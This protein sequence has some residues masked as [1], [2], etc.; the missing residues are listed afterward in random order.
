MIVFKRHWFVLQKQSKAFRVC[1]DQVKEN[2]CVVHVDFSEN[3]NC[4]YSEEIQAVHFGASHEQASLHTVVIYSAKNEPV[5]LCTVSSNLEH[6]PVGIWAHL[7]PVLW[8]IQHELPY[9]EHITMWSDGPS[10]Q[11]KQKNIFFRLC[12]DPFTYGF[13]SVSWNYFE[14]SHG[15]GAVDGVGAAVKRLADAAVH[16]G[17]DVNT[18]WAM[19][20]V[21]S[22]AS[23]SVKIFYIPETYFED[24][25]NQI[26]VLKGTRQ[27]HQI[28]CLR[29]GVISH[30]RLSCFCTWHNSSDRLCC[31][32]NP[33]T[34][35][36]AD[37]LPT[38]SQTIQLGQA[39]SS[40]LQ[41]R[42]V[43]SQPPTSLNKNK[44][45]L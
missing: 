34:F 37:V 1:K 14:S 43:G 29:P 35:T 38:H 40:S 20:K 42:K 10:T 44:V 17:T 4:K 39:E 9:V 45:I 16:N 13:K 24:S 25:K 5:C 6:S 11:Y 41:K 22:T 31:C 8:Y 28:N 3:Y 27:I 32:Y 7:K 12:T 33:R 23:R 26:P 21:V 2:E 19:F 30:R 18:P 36:F 15:K